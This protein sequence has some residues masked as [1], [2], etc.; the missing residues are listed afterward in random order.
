MCP[1]YLKRVSWC[2]P[3]GQKLFYRYSESISRLSIKMILPSIYRMS[4]DGYV[5]FSSKVNKTSDNRFMNCLLM[6]VC[7]LQILFLSSLQKAVYYPMIIYRYLQLK[8]IWY[9]INIFMSSIRQ[10]WFPIISRGCRDR[11]GSFQI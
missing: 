3:T 10:V 8:T 9:P 1:T 2:G 6:T 4:K 11:G 7:Y 5:G